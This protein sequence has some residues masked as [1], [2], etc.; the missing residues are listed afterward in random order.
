MAMQSMQT[1]KLGQ[2]MR[3][4]MGRNFLQPVQASKSQLELLDIAIP[5]KDGNEIDILVPVTKREMMAAAASAVAAHFTIGAA[6]A[7]GVYAPGK[8]TVKEGEGFVQKN[9]A[10]KPGFTKKVA[11]KARR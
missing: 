9:K 1:A 5:T 11:V 3:P 2:T 10:D 6:H 4:M 8:E 7:Y